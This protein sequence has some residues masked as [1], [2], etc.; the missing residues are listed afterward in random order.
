VS[1]PADRPA[2]DV[3]PL[4][5]SRTWE[6]PVLTAALALGLVLMAIQ[7]WILTVALDLLLGGGDAPLWRL[8]LASGA[9]FGG[10]LL[11]LKVLRAPPRPSGTP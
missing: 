11:V 6:A 7:L 10:G 9:V 8:A 5:P 3:P 1:E 2:P 4:P